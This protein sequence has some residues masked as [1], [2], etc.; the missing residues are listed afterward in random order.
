MNFFST[1]QK[2]QAGILIFFLVSLLCMFELAHIYPLKIV[3][4]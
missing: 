2:L 1:M 4:S 3:D